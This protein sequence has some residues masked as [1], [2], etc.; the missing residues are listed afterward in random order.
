MSSINIFA[1]NKPVW[2]SQMEEAVQQDASKP[3]ITNQGYRTQT[4]S[5]SYVLFLDTSNKQQATIQID[6]VINR[7]TPKEDF[8]L[9]VERFSSS[10]IAKD[11]PKIEFKNIGDEGFIWENIPSM[12]TIMFRK[13]DTFVTIMIT[14]EK[15]PQIAYKSELAKTLAQHI[16]R[17]MP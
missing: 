9:V 15:T 5:Y 7:T 14:G 2:L 4:A 13:G 8:N 11:Y 12:A 16:N 1:Q 10:K 17:Y 6:R 3:K